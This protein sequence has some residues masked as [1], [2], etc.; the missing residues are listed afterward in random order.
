MAYAVNQNLAM[1]RDTF[2]VTLIIDDTVEN[3]YIKMKINSVSKF[4]IEHPLIKFKN[5]VFKR[6]PNVNTP[7]LKVYW[8]DAEN[9]KIL[10]SCEED[11][12]MYLEQGHGKKIF[13]NASTVLP[14]PPI[15]D[16]EEVPMEAEESTSYKKTK[17]D[18]KA[19]KMFVTLY[20]TTLHPPTI[21]IYYLFNRAREEERKEERQKRIAKRLVEKMKQ[22]ED[23]LRHEEERHQRHPEKLE[24]K[25]AER[26]E[27]AKKRYEQFR[28]LITASMDPANLSAAAEVMNNFAPSTS[29]A[30]TSE[31]VDSMAMMHPSAET[32]RLLSSAIA[33]CLQP[34]NLINKILNEIIGMVPQPSGGEDSSGSSAPQ[35]SSDQQQQTEVPKQN[36]ATNTSD[37]NSP[38]TGHPSN[39]EIEALFKEAAKELE[40]MNE[41]VNNGK[42]S[43]SFAS[44]ASS[45]TTTG[46]TQIEKT[47]TNITDSAISNATVINA[48]MSVEE[49][50]DQGEGDDLMSFT[51]ARSR[52]SS[53][54]VHDINSMISEDSRDWTMLDA[55][56]GDDVDV[57]IS[58]D[59]AEEEAVQNVA[60][61]EATQ[62]VAEEIPEKPST[63]AIPKKIEPTKDESIKTASVSIETQTQ[64]SLMIDAEKSQAASIH[65]SIQTAEQINEIVKD[66]IATAQAAIKSIPTQVEEPQQAVQVEVA[67]AAPIKVETAPK[68]AARGPLILNMKETNP[69]NLR[70]TRNS[71]VAAKPAS[72]PTSSSVGPAV[73][74]YDA[75][76]KINAAVHQMMNMGFSNEEGWLTQLLINVDGDVAKAINFLTPQPKNIRKP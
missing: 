4:D 26:L 56:G 68:P 29:T 47:F 49:K 12:Q 31:N 72:R 7:N 65:K 73:I 66:S 17:L 67:A 3:F 39:E 28:Q 32:I 35:T 75:N 50:N 52:E 8:I 13:F 70:A 20:L 6:N 1:T 48:P 71:S 42:M 5:M 27:R 61:T 10:I 9:D 69:A 45:S 24:R 16:D 43:E 38:A 11:F 14:K 15:E 59:A 58:D 54:E 76:P 46:E 21:L 30:P 36:T 44:L 22:A 74:V 57:T 40:K 37:L 51:Q 25:T 23:K 41:I 60:E 55:P 2:K 33:G 63:G 62:I 34:C 64:S 19:K 18:R 53:I